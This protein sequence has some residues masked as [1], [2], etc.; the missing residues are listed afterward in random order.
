MKNKRVWIGLLPFLALVSC[1]TSA[2][3]FD[4]FVYDDS[5]TF[6]TSLKGA[7]LTDF[8]AEL[9]T[10]TEN[11]AARS[12]TTQNK[13]ILSSLESG[14]K[15]LLVNLVDRLA[16]SA[17]IEKADAA[18][19]SIIFFNREPLQS[20][21]STHTNMFYVGSNASQ[22]GKLQAELAEQLFPLKELNAKTCSFDKN[23][24][25]VIQIAIIKGEE[26]HQDTE[27][28]TKWCTQKLKDDGYNISILTTETGNWTTKGG[29][30]AMKS[31]ASNYYDATDSSKA[32]VELVFSNNDDMASGAIS[33]LQGEKILK[34]DV[35]SDQQPIQFIGF[36]GTLTGRS[37]ITSGLMYGT[38]LNDAAT[39]A[40]D[41]YNLAS[42]IISKSDITSFSQFDYVDGKLI[43][44][45]LL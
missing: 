20:D 1:G 34:D 33:Y 5:D 13:Q 19:A 45:A 11:D 37:L 22:A 27:L 12:Q 42:A 7:I 16:A 28:R 39:Q 21:L 23:G 35:T 40:K 8:G 29:E 41:I 24:D 38:V 44:K 9:P 25:G 10:F 18:K 6:I 26:G 36:D 17:I 4:L 30:T 31:I 14:T 15:L 2:H 43:T 32:N 3:K